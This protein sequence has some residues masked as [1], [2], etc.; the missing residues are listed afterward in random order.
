MAITSKELVEIM[1]ETTIITVF[2]L[3]T[4]Y[5]L[6]LICGGLMLR[7]VNEDTKIGFSLFKVGYMMLYSIVAMCGL[8]AIL[9]LLSNLL[10]K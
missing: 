8:S 1:N 2:S 5:S 9:A 7:L 10:L 3:Y 4:L 6:T